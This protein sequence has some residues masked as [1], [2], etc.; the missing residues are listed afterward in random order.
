MDE[1]DIEWNR[2]HPAPFTLFQGEDGRWGTKDAKGRVYDKPVYYRVEKDDGSI[3]FNNGVDEACEFDPNEGMSLICSCEPWWWAPFD[4]V[5][6]PEKYNG[7]IMYCIK[8]EPRITT[9][10]MRKLIAELEGKVELDNAQR[11]AVAG[12]M[13]ALEWEDADDDDCDSI[14]EDWFSRFPDDRNAEQ[15]I[16]VLEPLMERDDISDDSKKALWF[17]NFLFIYYFCIFS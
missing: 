13:M 14:E 9:N 3:V 6:F 15:R 8:S 4:M 12:L 1:Y 7:Y 17:A 10:D 11:Q 2:L 5:K 16:A